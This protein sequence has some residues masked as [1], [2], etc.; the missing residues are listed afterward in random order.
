[1]EY[2]DQKA[3]ERTAQEQFLANLPQRQSS[4]YLARQAQP[5]DKF[6]IDSTTIDE[7]IISKPEEAVMAK[8]TDFSNAPII[9]LPPAT[10]ELPKVTTLTTPAA[11]EVNSDYSPV[12]PTFYDA[13]EDS[14]NRG[15]TAYP[16]PQGKLVGIPGKTIAVDPSI[17]PVGSY[18]EVADA[19]GLFPNNPH[20]IF[21]AGDTGSA[22]KAG[23]A[24]KARGVNA[25][26]IDFMT[27]SPQERKQLASRVKGNL[28][29]R[30]LSPSEVEEKKRQGII[31]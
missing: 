24:A 4:E 31:T 28:K 9:N 23:T 20:G 1:M 5:M 3:Q 27:S 16:N 11:K 13:T 12:V 21:H 19:K 8:R 29:Y 2:N 30:I 18:V 7:G 22:V 25:P 15:Q 10:V 17:I 26:V 14:V 6:P